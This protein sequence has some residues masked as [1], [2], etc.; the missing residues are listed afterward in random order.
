MT[1]TKDNV[2]DICAAFILILLPG[3]AIGLLAVMERV[4]AALF[5][6]WKF[7]GHGHLEGIDIGA[8]TSFVAMFLYLLG[9]GVC[10]LISIFL[11]N[12]DRKWLYRLTI[13]ASAIYFI[14]GVLLFLLVSTKLAFLTCV[15]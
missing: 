14:N 4:Y 15:R 8:N 9:L 11:K 13:V 6:I 3:A 12:L 2:Q 1:V 7:Y 10:M 5:M